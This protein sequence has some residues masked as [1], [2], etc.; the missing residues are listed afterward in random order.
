M[1]LRNLSWIWLC[2]FT[3]SQLAAQEFSEDNFD[4]YT[5]TEGLSDNYI[6]G[7]AQDATGFMWAATLHGLN[8]YDGS[9]F[10]QYH[11]NSDSLS[12]ASEEL[13]GLV[14]LDKERLAVYSAG[15]HIINT[16]TNEA[17]NLFIPY[18]RTQYQYK[19]NMIERAIGDE[20]G[21]IYIL[22]RSGFYH[23]DKNYHLRF[24]FDYYSEQQVL[25]EH[26]FFGRDLLRLDDKRLLIVSIA[27]LYVYDT[28]KKQFKKMEAADCPLMAGFL[29]YPFEYYLFFQQKA[30]NIFILRPESDSLVYINTAANKKIVSTLPFK[31][32]SNDFYYRSRLIQ[33]SDTVFYITSHS[34]GFFKMRF[35]PRSGTVK[36]YPEKY[37][38]SYLCNNLIKDKDDNLWIATNKGL[39]RQDDERS[40]VQVARLPSGT[41]DKFPDIRVRDVYVSEDKIYAATRGE[42]GLFVF[43][44]KT[45]QS[46]AQIIFKQKDTRVNSIR[47]IIPVKSS[48]LLLGTNGPLMQ[49]D[50]ANRKEKLLT[51]QGWNKDD[52]TSDMY[53]DRNNNVW[54]SAE[55]IYRYNEAA[56]NFTIVPYRRQ[57]PNLFVEIAEDNKGNIWMAGHGV[58]RYNIASDSFDLLLDS[59]PFI[60]MPDKQVNAMTIDKQ[61]N[62]W[63][64]SNNNGLIVYNIDKGNFRHFTRTDGLPDN[65][66]SSLIALN[67]KLWIASYSGIACMDLQTSQIIS[68]GKEDGFPGIPIGKDSRFFYDTVLK[69]LY[70]C[71]ATAVIRFD[72][73]KMLQHKIKSYLFIEKVM[74]NGEKNNFLPHESITT[75]WR[76]NDLMI[77][78]GSINFTNSSSQGFAYRIL[79]D[80][81]AQWQQLG[82]QASFN[83]SNLSPGTHVIQV[84]CFSLNNRWPEQVKELKIIVLPPFWM[85]G[86]FI[87]LLAAATV[88]LMYVLIRLRISSIRRMEMEKTHIQKLK[89]DDYKNRFELEQI[90]NYFS[91]SLAVTKTEEEVLWDVTHNLMSRMNYE[92][93][94]IY[95]WNKDKTKMV[96]KAAYG[97]KGKPEI[98]LSNVFEV[99]PGQGIVGHAIKTRQPVLVND[100]RRDS[101]YRVD[102]DFRLSEVCVPI[103]HNNELLG[104]IDSE[105]S[106]PGYFS[107]RDIKI[108]TTI[109]TLIGN[110]LTQIKSEQSLEIKQKE[111]VSINEQLAEARLAALQA[112]MNPHFIFNALNSIKRMILDG[113]NEKAS[114]Y[115]SKFAL[116]IRMTLNHSK[117][118][119]V[120][121]DE[122]IEYLK[123]YLEMEQLR[124]SDSFTY[125]I[126]TDDNIDTLE[127][128]I[129]SLMM[130]P[131]VENAIWH[132][133]LQSETDKKI[134]VAFTQDQG[135]I[136]CMIEDNGIGINQSKEVKEKS[137]ST[138]R[139]VGLENLQKR[140]KM[141]NEK[142]NINCSLEITDL[143]NANRN[144]TKAV[145]KF[146]VTS[147]WNSITNSI[148]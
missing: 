67:N 4:H 80:S 128:S 98:I 127:T 84:K 106:E 6:T 23:F 121:L 143:K 39:F 89:A 91:S 146:N 130:Q 60:K 55:N 14:W 71:F 34:S 44:K 140:I 94:V 82:S 41:E 139:S 52:W 65:N 120:T 114:R 36:L 129:P 33:V 116:M 1:N 86:W 133:L 77:T 109:A 69:Q 56:Q 90:S 83:I 111:L 42:A 40:Q 137:N 79:K 48:T 35:Y 119:F 47:Y 45:L 72:P 73:D 87:M 16:K 30:G 103:I 100:T 66:I 70:L 147:F 96:Q 49:Y 26:F 13:T 138:H 58:A 10:A 31:A 145:L 50:I 64:N 53:R 99:L 18:H 29:N 136:T 85:K 107:E 22:S 3:V 125:A 142:Y 144:G 135:T 7:L 32:G 141:I 134:I 2:F 101:R 113:D 92:D 24:R 9:H 68:F 102:D 126:F 97:P 118:I 5:S 115:L 95:L 75:S 124:F 59:F 108:L 57:S 63:F 112:Q 46:A 117:E 51:L 21:N 105:H 122:N 76:N 123:A 15:L 54:I 78:I 8:R 131:L 37:F 74:I 81:L 28:E 148:S 38:R 27:G 12:L 61:N 110:K 88:V 104:A 93:C 43:D 11:S 19:F 132:G 62:I 25:T 20:K 17:R